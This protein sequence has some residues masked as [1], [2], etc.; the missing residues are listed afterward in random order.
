MW[1]DIE[2]HLIPFLKLN[3]HERA[4]YYHLSRHSR[5]LGNRVAVV[6]I[7]SLA[8]A[9]GLSTQV[10]KHLRN[11]EAKGALK[12]IKRSG[13]GTTVE[14]FAPSEIQGCV[15]ARSKASEI[16]LETLD[17]YTHKSG[18]SAILEREAGKC[19]Y[20]LCQIDSDSVVLDHAIPQVH[21]LD[22]SYRNIVACCHECNSLKAGA[23]ADDFLRAL[24]RR[25]RLSGD[26]LEN[27][28]AALDALKRGDLKPKVSQL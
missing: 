27:R 3:A 10:R 2:D 15:K 12:I 21:Q 8:R 19:F 28:L 13:S 20:C 5:L 26:E 1:M 4:V 25:K 24:Y 16:D 18:R 6:S 11:L 17:F 14:I 22:N 23:S 7:D 9:T